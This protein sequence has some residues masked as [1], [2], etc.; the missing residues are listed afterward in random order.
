MYELLHWPAAAHQQ[1]L[2][3]SLDKPVA[4]SQPKAFQITSQYE[5][6]EDRSKLLMRKGVYPYEYV[7][8][9]E[10]FGKTTLPPKVAF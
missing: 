5:P 10:C 2:I 3:A 1:H 6:N 9:G 8:S 7:G 4:A